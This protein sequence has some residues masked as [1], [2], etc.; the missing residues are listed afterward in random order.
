M[1]SRRLSRLKGQVAVETAILYAIVILVVIVGLVA[2][3]QTGILKPQVGRRGYVGFSQIVPVDWV[4][5][6]SNKVYLRVKN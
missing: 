5:A 1:N 2:V 3:W 4:V 6:R